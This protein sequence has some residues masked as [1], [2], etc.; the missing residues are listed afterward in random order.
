MTTI[1]EMKELFITDSVEFIPESKSENFFMLKKSI[2][3]AKEGS[4]YFPYNC[5]FDDGMC[6]EGRKG[7]K[8][9][10]WPIRNSM[11]CCDCCGQSV[12][13]FRYIF[14]SD[15][16]YYAKKWS[17]KTG[18]WRKGK[19]CILDR[20]YRSRTCLT[21]NC[22]DDYDFRTYIHKFNQLCYNLFE[23]SIKETKKG[24]K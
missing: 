12:G 9:R 7:K 1:K 20:K 4:K 19:G 10:K 18:F 6:K 13:Y 22:S 5:Q 23:L 16:G 17:K 11:C 21:H 3:T 8:E 2:Y 14:E 24:M 15:I